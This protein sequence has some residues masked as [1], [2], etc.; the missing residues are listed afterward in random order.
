[1]PDVYIQNLSKMF[2]GVAAVE[3]LNLTVR[4]GEF[5][6]L[7]GPS[8]CGKSTTLA[9]VAGLERPEK[10]RI[11]LGGNVL[12]DAATNSF[13]PAEERDFGMVFQSYALWPHMTVRQ[14]VEVPLRLRRVRRSKR[15]DRVETALDNVDILELAERYPHELSGGQQQRVALARALVYSPSVLLLD[16]PLS[17]LDAKLRD[18]ARGWLKRIQAETGVTTL[19]V[20]HDQVEA[21]AMSDRIAVLGNGQLLQVGS[22][23]EIYE[24]PVSSEVADFIGHYNFLPAQISSAG[25]ELL[26]DGANKLINVSTNQ[27]NITSH[28]GSKVSVAV[29]REK[30]EIFDVGKENSNIPGNFVLSADVIQCSYVGDYY[31]YE[32]LLD[33]GVRIFGI[34]I[35]SDY[36]GKVKVSIPADACHIFDDSKYITRQEVPQ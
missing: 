30:I 7:L 18:R 13:V 31:E 28:Q 14:N 24:H 5:F 33:S 19:Y 26:V 1:M 4:D 3:S 6:T 32:L 16:E 17:N 22:P 29:Q 27:S 25:D 34:N 8:G 23:K 15:L 9:N 12:V 36:R 20:T 21:L 2:G 10:G 35:D 11:L